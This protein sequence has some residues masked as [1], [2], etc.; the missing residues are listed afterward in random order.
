MRENYANNFH[1]LLAMCI[2]HTS[3]LRNATVA[4]IYSFFRGRGG[5]MNTELKA[6]RNEEIKSL[7]TLLLLLNRRLLPIDFH[8][9]ARC[10]S[11]WN[12]R[13]NAVN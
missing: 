13:Y 11:L 12:N 2:W 3:G 7:P 10:C 1:M 4:V 5:H 8:C 6:K 9:N